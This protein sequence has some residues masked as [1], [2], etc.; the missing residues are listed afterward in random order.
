MT[1]S[2]CLLLAVLLLAACGSEGGADAR[3]SA[4]SA[5][6]PATSASG[7]DSAAAPPPAAPEPAPRTIVLAP[8]GLELAG[9]AGG[10]AKL[11]FGGPRAGALAAVSG[12]LGEPREQGA[13]EE[14]PAG[15]L[16][17]AQ[18][19]AGLQVVFQDS[20]FVGWSAG[21]GSTFRTA[22]GIGPGSTVAQLKAAYPA[23]TVEETSLGMEFAASELYGIVTDSTAA[24]QVQM[25][26]AGTNCI[27]R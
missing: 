12:V 18:Y 1:N 7:A 2:R 15:P 5:A 14:C 21:E 25:M 16:Y 26:F 6:V 23:A 11:A 4:D 3:S 8:D 20:A 24:G 27:F 17:Q 9:G 19:A 10:A 13:Q 22:S